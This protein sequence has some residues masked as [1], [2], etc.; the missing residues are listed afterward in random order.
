MVVGELC[1]R[2]FIG[3][4]TWIGSTEDLKV[5]LNLLVDTFCFTIRL[6][7]IGSREGEVVIQEFPKLLSEG[8]GKLW[9]T[10]RDDLVVE[11]EL[12][13]Y[14]ME[15][16]GS[17]PLSGDGFLCGAENYPLHK[18]MVN[19][20]QQR[21]KTRRSRK[22]GDKVAGDLLEGARGVGL[23]WGERRDGGVCV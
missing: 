20:N 9:A 19:H 3:P 23:D 11:P 17:Y 22:V 2:D 16:E 15:K 13:V 5:C 7:V 10:I 8:K 18:A 12:E 1:M 14:L 4:G 21:V 6:G